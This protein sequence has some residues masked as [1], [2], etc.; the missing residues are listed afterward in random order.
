LENWLIWIFVDIIYVG[1]Y[2]S[3]DLYATAIMYALYIYIAAIGY[4][5]WRKTYR[6]QNN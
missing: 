2:I 6:E 4:L 1:V 5:N 3:K